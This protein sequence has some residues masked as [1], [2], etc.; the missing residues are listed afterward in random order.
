MDLR[1]PTHDPLMA[2]FGHTLTAP[3]VPVATVRRTTWVASLIFSDQL[4]PA[5]ALRP[6][7]PPASVG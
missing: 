3:Q 5:S 6:G 1:K 7:L 2:S 4:T